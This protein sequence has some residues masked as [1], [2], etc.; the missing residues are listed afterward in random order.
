M[1][2]NCSLLN[3]YLITFRLVCVCVCVCVDIGYEYDNPPV[4]DDAAPISKMKLATIYMGYKDYYR[5]IH[6][7]EYMS[8]N[9]QQPNTIP[10]QKN[11]LTFSLG[12]A[13]PNDDSDFH[14]IFERPLTTSDNFPNYYQFVPGDKSNLLFAKHPINTPNNPTD[15][16]QHSVAKL[17]KIDF[18]GSYKECG[19]V[20]TKLLALPSYLPVLEEVEEEERIRGSG[21]Q[22]LPSVTLLAV[23]FILSVVTTL[24]FT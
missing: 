9:Y 14:L 20:S 24:V 2:C 17:R 22:A 10:E 18:F 16:E 19:S 1:R 21:W 15:F 8:L 3:P 12:R 6:I 23:A 11:K 4:E 13:G 7:N 5:N